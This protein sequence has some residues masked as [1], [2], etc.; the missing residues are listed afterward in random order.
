[1]TSQLLLLE[2]H[3]QWKLNPTTRAQGL[4]GIANARAVLRD[5][6]AKARAQSLESE[7]QPIPDAA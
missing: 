4:R 3:P 5:V 7:P 6:Q 1:M 2:G